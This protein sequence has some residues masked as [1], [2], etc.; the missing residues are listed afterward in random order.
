MGVLRG[1][2]KK[3]PGRYWVM[4]PSLSAE[5]MQFDQSLG[6]TGLWWADWEKWLQGIDGVFKKPANWE[7]TICDSIEPAPGSYVLARA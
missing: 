2:N 7:A 5:K 1:I 4:D 6:K 3:A